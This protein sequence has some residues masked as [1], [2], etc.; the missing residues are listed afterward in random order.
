MTETLPVAKQYLSKLRATIIKRNYPTQGW[1]VLDES[2]KLLLTFDQS[3]SAQGQQPVSQSVRQSAPQQAVIQNN[4]LE[5]N[6]AMHNDQLGTAVEGNE[7]IDPNLIGGSAMNMYNHNFS[8]NANQNPMDGLTQD[9][10]DQFLPQPEFDG[11]SEQAFGPSLFEDENA[12]G[13]NGAL[14]DFEQAFQQQ[15]PL[16]NGGDHQEGGFMS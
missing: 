10:N 6:W 13:S 2:V 16:N 14:D 9:L 8:N 12:Y 3:Q 11:P 5:N 15:D 1:Q 7:A 4:N